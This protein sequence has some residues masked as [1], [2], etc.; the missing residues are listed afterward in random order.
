METLPVTELVNVNVR[1]YLTDE[2]WVILPMKYVQETDA[3]RWVEA[4]S[5]MFIDRG[6][7]VLLAGALALAR[8]ARTDRMTGN[9]DK[10]SV[11]NASRRLFSVEWYENTVTAVMYS[12][13]TT[14]GFRWARVSTQE[15]LDVSDMQIARY[16]SEQAARVGPRPTLD[17]P[18]QPQRRAHYRYPLQLPV[19]F[20]P[21]QTDGRTGTRVP[22]ELDRELNQ[23]GMPGEMADLSTGGLLMS[24]PAPLKPG[25]LVCLGLNLWNQRLVTVG[26]VRRSVPAESQHWQ[27]GVQFIGLDPAYQGRIAQYLFS[28][29]SR[30]AYGVAA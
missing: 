7:M 30:V 10:A 3:F 19:Q 24:V 11:V 25:D 8:R 12:A 9:W 22:A 4:S 5:P 15:W 6:E 28:E 1:V 16:L 20:Y 13:I 26:Q 29:Q 2:V 21:V 18:R 27:V 17:R 23:H 14:G